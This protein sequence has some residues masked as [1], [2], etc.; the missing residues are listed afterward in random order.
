MRFR[1]VLRCLLGAIL[2]LWNDG[3][4]AENTQLFQE[5]QGKGIQAIQ[6]GDFSGGIAFLTEAFAENDSTVQVNELL[7]M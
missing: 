3:L 4:N 2:F 7:G 1:I 6:I 5:L